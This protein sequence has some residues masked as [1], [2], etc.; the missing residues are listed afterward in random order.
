MSAVEPSTAR[1]GHAGGLEIRSLE[2]RFDASKIDRGWGKLTLLVG[3]VDNSDARKSIHSALR[4]NDGRHVDQEKANRYWWLDCG[5]AEFNGQVLLGSAE[6]ANA[7]AGSFPAQKTCLALPSP[8]LQHPE[9]LKPKPE[10]TTKASGMT[11]AELMAA[12]AQ[13]LIVNQR[14]AAE[15]ADYVARLILRRPLKKFAT[16]VDLDSGTARG[17]PITPEAVAKA[18]RVKLEALKR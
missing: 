4:F 5:N 3:C 12:N 1:Y 2:S 13:S 16:Y 15:A 6:K 9:L 14:I 18:A 17:V 7:L 11:C 8:A 10:E